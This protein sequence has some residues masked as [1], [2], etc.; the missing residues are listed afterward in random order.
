[1]FHRITGNEVFK[2]F[3]DTVYQVIKFIIYIYID[4]FL[5]NVALQI[6]RYAD[7]ACYQ[8]MKS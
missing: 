1:M 5:A 7:R 3:I 6:S 2:E 8:S 4:F